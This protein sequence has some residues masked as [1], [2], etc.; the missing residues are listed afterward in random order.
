MT[1]EDTETSIKQLFM[2]VEEL[3][4][5]NQRLSERVSELE[6]AK[7]KGDTVFLNLDRYVKSNNALHAEV[8][9]QINEVNNRFQ[10]SVDDCVYRLDRLDRI[11]KLE[12]VK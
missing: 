11:N 4:T 5:D 6:S 1:Y 2:L 10:V 3:T 12:V 9:Q 7:A 8:L